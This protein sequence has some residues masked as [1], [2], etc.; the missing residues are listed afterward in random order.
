MLISSGDGDTEIDG[1]GELETGDWVI[2]E[3]R[4]MDL[5]IDDDRDREGV[6]DREAGDGVTEEVR[7]MVEEKEIEGELDGMQI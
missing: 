7:E 6:R 1:V 4:E 5:V 3:D 2:E